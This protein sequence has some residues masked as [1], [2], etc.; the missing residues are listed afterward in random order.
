MPE[1]IRPPSYSSQPSQN[2]SELGELR[3]APG[4]LRE[5][6]PSIIADQVKM[7]HTSTHVRIT[8]K[9]ITNLPAKAKARTAILLQD[10]AQPVAPAR[11]HPIVHVAMLKRMPK[12]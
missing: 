6:A 9:D 8:S 11:T 7:P 4:A 3:D 5:L 12:I 1:G 10:S 2:I